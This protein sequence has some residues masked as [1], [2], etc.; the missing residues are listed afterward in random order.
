MRYKLRAAVL[1]MALAVA[2][3]SEPRAAMASS[4]D[5]LQP[6]GVAWFEDHWIDLAADWEAATACD[7]GTA[8]SVCFRT[9]AEL[10]DYLGTAQRDDSVSLLATCGSS[11]RLYD[12]TSYTPTMLSLS[13]RNTIH[14]LATYGFDNKTSSYKVGAC[15]TE[16]NSLINLAG[17]TY[18]GDTS[19]F[20]QSSSMLS[21]WNNVVSSVYIY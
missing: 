4:A 20:A 1:S 18:P 9:E 8:L 2:F 13:V 3:V 21:G 15:D 6:A 19:A 17:S 11:L 7:I 5:D 12:G 14:N 10:E 16:F